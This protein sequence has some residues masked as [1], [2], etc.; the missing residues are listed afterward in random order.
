VIINDKTMQK[1][2]TIR[3][4]LALLAVIAVWLIAIGGGR[5]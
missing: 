4:V 1:V 5:P 2:E 3:S